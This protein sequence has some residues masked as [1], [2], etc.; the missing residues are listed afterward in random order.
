MKRPN[1]LANSMAGTMNI[2]VETN[3]KEKM[4]VEGYCKE[5]MMVEDEV[6]GYYT[7]WIPAN[8]NRNETRG[9]R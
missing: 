9:F 3:C 2:G 8:A 5:K 1:L 6:G 4:M 7:I